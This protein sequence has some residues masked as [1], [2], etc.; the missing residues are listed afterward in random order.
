MKRYDDGIDDQIVKNILGLEILNDNITQEETFKA[1]ASLKKGKS[2][3]LDMITAECV[4]IYSQEIVPHLQV[5]YNYILSM[6]TY[7][8][9]WTQG[10][11]IAIPKRED[12]IMSN[13]NR[14]NIWEFI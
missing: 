7:P 3:G 6:E 10:L 9:K 4:N 5:L 8:E 14:T 2:P 11:C 12:D 13:Y 1:I